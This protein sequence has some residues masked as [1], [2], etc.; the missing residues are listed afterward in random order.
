ML[1]FISYI[2]G[3]LTRVFELDITVK[4]KSVLGVDDLLLLL[5]YHWARDTSTFPTER[6]RVQFAPILLLLLAESMEAVSK[7]RKHTRAKA[8]YSAEIWA[9]SA[10]NN[11]LHNP[12]ATTMAPRT[13]KE[14]NT[15]RRKR[16]RGIENKLYELGQLGL[17]VAL[18]L[19][20]PGEE[21]YYVPIHTSRI[22]AAIEGT[23]CE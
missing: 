12:L 2:Y 18:F 22:V 20:N 13:I 11:L 5:N 15:S 7:R 21:E 14:R 10:R 16:K 3:D 4:E 1:T 17:D 8:A 6:H 23:D 19:Y 9:C